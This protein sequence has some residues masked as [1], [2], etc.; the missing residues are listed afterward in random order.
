MSSPLIPQG[1]ETE[2]KWS[3]T[4]LFSQGPGSDLPLLWNMGWSV[5]A[6]CLAAEL[7]GGLSAQNNGKGPQCP[8][9][10]PPIPSQSPTTALP[11]Q[12]QY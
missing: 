3:L 4:P 2:N 9:S 5:D 7:S 8:P 12:W 1:T 11:A 10:L 6:R